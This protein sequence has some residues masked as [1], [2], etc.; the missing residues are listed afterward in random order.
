MQVKS[1]P[2]TFKSLGFVWL[3]SVGAAHAF[4]APPDRITGTVDNRRATVIPGNISRLAQPSADRGA[5][6]PGKQMD[7]IVLLFKPSAAQQA[8]LDQLLVDQ[9]NPSSP[10][11]HQWLTPEEFADQFGLSSGDQSKAVAWLHSEGFQV[12]HSA[13]GRNWVAFSGTAA[14]VS[15]ALHTSIHRFDVNGETHFANTTEPSVPEALAGVVGG[16][17]GLNDFYPK[18]HAVLVPDYNSSSG[19]HYLAPGDFETIYDIT[20]LYQAGFNG[21]GQSIAVVGESDVLLSDLQAFRT[22]YGLPANNPK[23]LLYDTDPGFNSADQVEANLDLEWAGAIAPA[24]TIYYVYGPD[25]ITA[26]VAAVDYNVA[27]V[28]SISFGYCEI[29]FDP[30]FY[31]AITQQANAQGITILSASGDTGA[32]G[33]HETE[34]LATRGLSVQFPAALPQVT[35]VGGTEFVESNGAYW[36]TTNSTAFSSALS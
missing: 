3:L 30:L 34:P 36:G 25:A 19:A 27:P 7:Y 12:K 14:Q 2:I 33:C 32:A 23:M 11:F 17:L 29:D 13:R 8:E 5:V 22:R 15:A 1:F 20:P 31:S 10:R 28:I 35:G 21:T 24:A 4:A 26:A 9:Q 16:F 18:P 6:D